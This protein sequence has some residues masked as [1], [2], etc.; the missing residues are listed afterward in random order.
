MQTLTVG[1]LGFGVSGRY[2]HAPII[3]S[4]KGLRVGAILARNQEAGSFAAVH[5]PEAACFE[6]AEA[7]IHDS[8]VE[9][10]HDTILLSFEFAFGVASMGTDNARAPMDAS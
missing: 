5:Y 2:F 10:I 6:T 1:L 9:E 8:G 7:L 3:E 4:V